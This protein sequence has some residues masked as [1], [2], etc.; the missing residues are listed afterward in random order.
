MKFL[1]YAID[2]SII[3]RLKQIWFKFYTKPSTMNLNT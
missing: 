2:I 3:T 1:L